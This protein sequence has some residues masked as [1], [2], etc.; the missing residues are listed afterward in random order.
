[1]RQIKPSKIVFGHTI[2][3]STYLLTALHET[4]LAD[5]K[6]VAAYFSSDIFSLAAFAVVSWLSTQIQ[7][8]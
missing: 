5:S 1:V 6:A 8:A 4:H 7:K 2:I 3:S